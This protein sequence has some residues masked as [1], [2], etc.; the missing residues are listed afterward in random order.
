VR[1]RHGPYAAARP[2]Q[3]AISEM[4]LHSRSKRGPNSKVATSCH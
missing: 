2:M 3:R 4:S 1:A